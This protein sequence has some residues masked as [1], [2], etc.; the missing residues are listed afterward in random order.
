MVRKIARAFGKHPRYYKLYVMLPRKNIRQGLI[1]LTGSFFLLFL[2]ACSFKNVVP[3]KDITYL[4]ADPAEKRNEQKL[5]VFS[6]RNGDGNADVFIFIHGGV[7]NSGRRDLYTFLGKGMASKGVVAVIINYPLSPAADYSDMARAA[8]SSVK[9]VKEN[10]QHYGGNPARIFV[11]GHSAGGHLAALISV[12]DSYFSEL[13]IAN[14]IRGAIL[15]D[16]A[17]TDMYDYLKKESF[18][19]SHTFFKTFTHDENEWRKA[20]PIYQLHAGMPPMLIYVGEKTYPFIAE[21]NARFA[22]ALK[23][24]GDAPELHILKKKKH[25]AMITQ[26]FNPDNRC[27]EEIIRFMRDQPE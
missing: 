20:S 26:F 11:A 5:N 9:W 3:G 21:G 1:C 10:I 14:P 22:E 13:G 6:P 16:A 27:Y 8:A 17:G 15:I 25:V 18:P 7:W 4:Q 12:Q 23:A 2:Q 24:A 19:A